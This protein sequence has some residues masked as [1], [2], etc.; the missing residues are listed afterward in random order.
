MPSGNAGMTLLAEMKA[1]GI[2][3]RTLATGIGMDQSFLNKVMVGKKPWPAGLLER[4]QT[5]VGRQEVPK[6]DLRLAPLPQGSLSC[7]D[8]AMAYLQ[9]GWSIV[10]QMPGSKTP[11]IKW[12]KYQEE[13]PAESDSAGWFDQWP[14]AG[15]ALVLGPVSDVLVIDVDGPEAHAVLLER[16]GSEPVAPK[17]ISGSHEPHRYHLFFRCPNLLTRSKQT[18]WHQKLEFRGKGGI[19]IIPPSLHKSHS[20][21]P[22]GRPFARRPAAAALAAP[23]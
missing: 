6:P 16:L 7:R 22:A 19:V 5:W 18:P 14:D 21:M 11:R 9:R 15:L 10:P 2:S 13:L 20:A 1:K 4:T 8:W 12:K 17:A 23:E 3:R